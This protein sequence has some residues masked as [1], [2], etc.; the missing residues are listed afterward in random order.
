MFNSIRQAYNTE[1]SAEKVNAALWSGNLNQ[2]RSI[3]E[4][5]FILQQYLSNCGYKGDEEV[6]FFKLRWK[7]AWLKMA[8]DKNWSPIVCE[9]YN[10]I[11]IPSRIAYMNTKFFGLLPVGAIDRYQNGRGSMLVKLMN[12]FKITDTRGP[13]MDAAELV[14]ILAEAVI[15]PTYFLQNYISC[16]LINVNT[17]K[18][19]INDNGIKAT[20][21]FYF[22]AFGEFIA[23]ETLDRYYSSK[24]KFQR[25]RWTIH[26]DGYTEQNGIRFPEKF[27]AVWH[28]PEG[29]YE[30]FI[31]TIGRI[32]WNADNPKKKPGSSLSQR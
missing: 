25:T 23:F 27:R 13:E 22:N 26:V 5:P 21:L 10:F 16:Q 1:V 31:G 3:T 2:S 11:P 8:P 29:E 7:D 28:L 18:G 30:Y 9:Q 19:I 6:Q 4:L 32:E 20:G 24:G 17:I 14:T 15:F 12:L